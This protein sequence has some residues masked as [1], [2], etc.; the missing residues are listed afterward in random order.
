MRIAK[1]ANDGRIASAIIADQIA[2]IVSPWV[3]APHATVDFDL[4]RLDI[5]QLHELRENAREAIALESLSLMPPVP[6]FA[7]LICLGL[8]YRNHVEET[9]NDLPENPSLFTKL[10]DALV[11]Q[12]EDIVKPRV[13]DHFDYEGEIT[14]V[15][16]KAG[17]HISKEDALSHVF[18]Y[19]IMLDGSVRD[20]QKHSASTGKNFWKSGS[21]GPWIVTADE[22]PDPTHLALETRL[23]GQTVQK[24]TADLMLYDIPTAISYISRWTPLAPGDIIATGTPGGVGARRSPP[25]WMKKDDVIEV[26]VSSVG[27]LRNMVINED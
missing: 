8:N 13:S 26:E 25:L 6:P 7:K 16:G 4:P 15:I 14:V 24:T 3:A 18:G 22:I 11:G 12:G 10:P 20:Y 27:I 5:S 19:T 9:H 1:V 21:L 23:N 2:H 17:R